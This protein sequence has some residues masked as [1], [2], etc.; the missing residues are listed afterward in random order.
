MKRFLPIIFLALIAGL[1]STS[2][3]ADDKS[4]AAAKAQRFPPRR[5]MSNAGR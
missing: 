3:S 5:K 2:L 1:S 4:V